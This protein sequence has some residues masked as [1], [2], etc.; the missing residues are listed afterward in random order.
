MEEIYKAQNS[1]SIL[2]R[3]KNNQ[4]VVAVVILLSRLC[5]YNRNLTI[6][7]P[8][9][10][11]SPLAKRHLVWIHEQR[12]NNILTVTIM[13]RCLH[14]TSHNKY[15][16]NKILYVSSLSLLYFVLLIWQLC[17]YSVLLDILSNFAFHVSSNR[18]RCASTDIFSIRCWYLK[19]NLFN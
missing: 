13:C 5:Y 2:S 15:S 3:H 6:R 17:C 12:H 9:I 19:L 4:L 16:F 14:Y 11:N 10:I 1:I 8:E 18:E 7:Y